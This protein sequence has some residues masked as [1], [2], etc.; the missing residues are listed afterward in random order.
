MIRLMLVDSD[1]NAIS[2]QD[3]KTEPELR[4]AAERARALVRECD[5]L[6]QLKL[7]PQ[8]SISVGMGVPYSK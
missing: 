1:G 6:A 7:P 2:P 8:P 3:L 5:R 4:E